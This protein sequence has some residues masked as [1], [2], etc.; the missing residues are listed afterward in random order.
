MIQFYSVPGPETTPNCL[1]SLS[2]FLTAY[3]TGVVLLSAYSGALVSFLAV[4]TRR[5]LP[6][7][8]F[9]GL[10]HDESYSIGMISSSAVD[11]FRVRYL[12]I[13]CS[14]NN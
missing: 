11:M 14:S 6:F 5:E 2:V 9:Q 10:L 13:M 8:G 7:K 12:K 3:L 4:Q 1:S